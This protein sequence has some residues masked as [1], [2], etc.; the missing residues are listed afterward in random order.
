MPLLK[1]AVFFFFFQIIASLAICASAITNT[2]TNPTESTNSTK[3]TKN[4]QKTTTSS[5]TTKKTSSKETREKRT[6]DQFG[7]YFNSP[8]DG[9]HLYQINFPSSNRRISTGYT[10]SHEPR[11]YFTSKYATSNAYN[12]PS[13]SSSTSYLQQYRPDSGYSSLFGKDYDLQENKLSN[14]ISYSPHSQYIEAPE[15]I[16]EIIIKESNET[17]APQLLP[18]A[19]PLKKPKEQVQVFYV[20]YKKDDQKGLIIDE[21]VPALSPLSHQQ[22]QQD[23]EEDAPDSSYVVTLPP[24]V[25]STTLRTIIHPDSEKYHS[26][27]GIHVT[28]N[29]EDKNQAGHNYQ[30]FIEESALQP[31][32]V[33]AR[34]QPNQPPFSQFNPS[35]QD[36]QS[37]RQFDQPSFER[38][39]Q[40]NGFDQTTNF[41]QFNSAPGGLSTNLQLPL[42]HTPTQPFRPIQ[43]RPQFQPNRFFSNNQQY[44]DQRNKNIPPFVPLDDQNRPSPSGQFFRPP[45]ISQQPSRN[46]LPTR[47]QDKPIPIPIH[48]YKQEQQNVFSRHPSFGQPSDAPAA[49]QT[50][51]QPPIHNFQP[52]NK[53]QQPNTIQE[54]KSKPTPPSPHFVFPNT[55]LTLPSPQ[56]P[57]V[58]FATPNR[59]ATYQE[60]PKFSQ[61]H[62]QIVQSQQQQLQQQTSS[63]QQ[64][65]QLTGTGALV[66]KNP[67]NLNGLQQHGLGEFNQL[68]PGAELIESVPKYEQ[69]ITQTIPLS[70]INQPFAQPL[71][72][73]GS[74][75]GSNPSENY[76]QQQSVQNSQFQSFNNQQ[77]NQNYI[78]QQQAHFN[79]VQYATDSGKGSPS[80]DSNAPQIVYPMNQKPETYE[81]LEYF[82][83]QQLKNIESSPPAHAIPIKQKIIP[84]QSVSTLADEVFPQLESQKY[85]AGYKQSYKQNEDLTGRNKYSVQQTISVTQKPSSIITSA[86]TE[87]IRSTTLLSTTTTKKD[88]ETTTVKTTKK[89]KIE[90]PDEVPDDLR[91]QLLSSGILDNADISVLDYDKIGDVPL[92]SLPPEHLANFYGAGGASQI[93]SSNKV[94]SIVKPN[95]ETIRQK[96]NDR[97]PNQLPTD[98]KSTLAK[99]QNVELKVVRFD[100]NNQ[101]SVTD[102]YIKPD[103]TVLPSVDVSDRQF[104]RYLPLKVDGAQFPIPDVPELRGRKIASVVVLA[105]VDGVHSSESQQSSDE[106]RFE[107]DV[108]DTKQI[109]FIAG[110]SLKQLLKKPTKEN[111]KKWLDKESKTDVDSQSVVLLVMR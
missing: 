23:E 48:S 74:L 2:T 64:Q 71:P 32:V 106:T 14:E 19:L 36:Y 60:V 38:S 63:A 65:N 107:R 34:S 12:V 90:L 66:Q 88:A 67:P 5:T 59:P 42:Q 111:F 21:P 105:P 10:A 1:K 83:K 78:N 35:P 43:E 13:S 98:A 94:I 70:Q 110:D 62:Q 39:R 76:Q 8:I 79:S 93:S 84:G 22:E 75:L 24:P 41:R 61:S 85:S 3:I 68:A 100:S 37:N 6:L 26:N 25:K 31:V 45:Q 104:N 17:L 11:A 82:R 53:I 40:V 47:N 72:L 102:Q 108:I 96:S 15:P 49:P 20:K 56:P 4:P 97:Q 33:S 91:E 46:R 103:S 18:Q 28:F 73:T 9:G 29:T 54:F 58:P 86:A 44:F 16:I 89:P 109:K 57:L 50:Y 69:H 95:G 80:S 27:S 55:Q 7:N 87:K 52:F 92:E 81:Q 51:F 77:Q 101:K 99:K 30:E